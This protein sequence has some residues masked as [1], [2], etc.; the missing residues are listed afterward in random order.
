MGETAKTPIPSLVGDLK[1]ADQLLSNVIYF[2]DELQHGSVR[3][4]GDARMALARVRV[5]LERA[6]QEGVEAL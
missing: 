2:E 4:I 6:G 5:A 3:S 1:K